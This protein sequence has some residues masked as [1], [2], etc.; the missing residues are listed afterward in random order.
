M[1]GVI[2][3][4]SYPAST[5]RELLPSITNGEFRAQIIEELDDHGPDAE[6][7]SIRIDHI[8][9]DPDWAM[10]QSQAPASVGG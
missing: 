5:W 4:R 10:A 8:I 1:N 9:D 3:T 6:H 2:Y 7:I